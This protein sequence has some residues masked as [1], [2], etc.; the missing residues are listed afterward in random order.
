MNDW[1]DLPIISAIDYFQGILRY[2]LNFA[3]TYGS[4]FGLI[5]LVWTGIRL[6]NSRIDLRSAWWDSL[7]KWFIFLLLINFYAAGTSL[8]SSISNSV[9]LN[10]G[11][12]KS[13]I[14][15]NFTSLKTRIEAEIK[16]YDKWVNGLTD[17]VNAELG[18]ELDYL[19]P[20]AYELDDMSE[21][22]VTYFMNMQNQVDNHKFSS[23][24][25]RKEFQ[26]KIDA[27]FDT[28]PDQDNSI[29]G[30][31]TLE[32]LN[33]IL[34]VTSA[35]GS[36]KQ[37]FTGAY[38]TDKPELNIWLKN[39]EGKATN[40]LSSSAIFRIG[41]LTS[42]IIWEKA[43]MDVTE[44][45]N[46][47]G[48]IEY[49]I[50]K[51]NKFSPKK[52]GTYIMTGICCLCII[53][54]VAFALIQYVMC[55]LEFTIVQGIGAAFIPFYLFDGTKDIPKKLLPVFTGFAIKILVMVICLMFVI[56]MYLNFA[57]E[58]ISPTSGS[59]GFPAFAECIFI[60]LLS[61]VLTSNAP[62]I[63]MTLLTG[64][65]QLSMGELVQAAATFGAGAMATKNLA[66][67][68]ASPA[69]A[70]A[71]RKAHEWGE[72]RGAASSARLKQEN[73]M[74]TQFA[75][76]HG[77]DTS[78]RSGRKNLENKWDIYRNSSDR[79]DEIDTKL[80]KVGSAAK[81]DVKL[82]QQAEYQKNGGI[83]GETGRM[84]AHYGGALA[85]PKQTLMQGLQYHSPIS[86]IDVDR[87]GAEHQL[88]GDEAK[89]QGRGPNKEPVKNDVKQDE[90]KGIGGERQVE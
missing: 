21:D 10:A 6:V 4:F 72:Q 76:E 1:I 8:V 33:S 39:S 51:N 70:Q 64:Q 36:S 74:K 45:V 54:A 32:A 23:K 65:P 62:K 71:K 63:A 27:Y 26:R 18:I 43:F 31:Q 12:G 5:G 48:E 35:D 2:F 77:I 69:M 86:N 15:K 17:L 22:A 78:T 49:K 68:V 16:V 60:C 25:Q 55:I 53:F 14:I 40:Y 37:N 20:S 88:I 46:S 58:Q 90:I 80:N 47:D 59:M 84:L 11:N 34:I 50:K 19:D 81:E 3:R 42:Q 13:T 75:A 66:S 82:R 57:A 52:I 83:V 44:K 56:N 38:V 89:I 67:T 79:K 41:V 29:W 24:Q 9:G 87:I 85:N 30:S 73:A 61:F 28:M 7:S